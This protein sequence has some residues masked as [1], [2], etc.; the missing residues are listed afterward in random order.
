MIKYLLKTLFITLLI[1]LPA[2]AASDP[3]D[4]FPAPQPGMHRV[5]IQLPEKSR[6][7][8]GNFKL[9]LIVGKIM[10]TDG[11]NRIR[12]GTSI[13][14]QNL[15]GWGYHYYAVE[16]TGVAISTK[17]AVL[18]GAEEIEQFVSTAPILVRYNSR[19]PVVVY[20]P[21]EYELR[22]RIWE[23]PMQFLPATSN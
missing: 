11:V 21:S 23:A 13:S 12:L 7:Q 14:T 22:Y 16:E 17:I 8:E 2:H 10:M 6:E 4:A 3:L 9:E 1:S 15:K 20:L 5:V 18:D 19:L